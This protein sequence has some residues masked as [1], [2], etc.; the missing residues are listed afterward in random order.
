M[1]DIIYIWNLKNNRNECIEKQIEKNKQTSDENK[2]VEV[3]VDVE[4]MSMDI[5]GVHV[6][7]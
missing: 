4:Y 3:E 2:M 1:Q 7:G 6:H 5:H